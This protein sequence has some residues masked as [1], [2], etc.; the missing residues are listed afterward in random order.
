MAVPGLA[1]V[2]PAYNQAQF[3]PDTIESVLGQDVP[4]EYLVINDGSTDAT[5]SVL[6]GFGRCLRSISRENRGQTPTIN[7]GWTKT[8][9]PIIG[10]LNSDDTLLPGA[11][12]FAVEYLD[13][14]PEVDIVYGTT[15]FTD[16]DGKVLGEPA[17]RPYD[18]DDVLR[19]GLNPI[20]QPSAF[21]RR[22][23]IEHVG[24]L[25]GSLYYFMDWDL[26]LRAGL[27]HRIVH[28]PKPLST[29]RLHCASK[30]VAEE[31]RVAPE[32][33]RVYEGYFRRTDIPP[34]VKAVEAEALLFAGLTSAV[35]LL[36]GGDAPGARR[37]TLRAMRSN[38]R[39]ALNPSA[40][41]R[42]AYCAAGSTPPY[43]AIRRCR[44]QWPA[45][46]HP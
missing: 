2:T 31:R 45:V 21:L 38:P 27:H 14:H 34:E 6:D 46:V 20:P 39:L 44:K 43:R 19:R 36:H 17:G 35:Y 1:I 28:V 3:L 23:V 30:T 41:R 13:A 25:D 33:L 32:I 7:E 42:A 18:R 5:H 12:R 29:Y 26:W 37:L 24:P 4:V 11:A 10:W 40:L 15:V 9:A 22:R 8:S 16:A